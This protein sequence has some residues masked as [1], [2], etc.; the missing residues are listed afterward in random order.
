MRILTLILALTLAAPALAQE[1]RLDRDADGWLLRVDGQPYLV[2]GV[3]WRY[4]PLGRNYSFDAWRDLPRDVCERLVDEDAAQMKKMGVNTI[5]VIDQ[6]GEATWVVRR[7]YEKH[8]IHTI[9]NHFAGRYGVSVD[10]T[11][12]FP[13]NYADKRAREVVVGDVTAWA[14]TYKDVPGV[15]AYALGNEGNYGLEW[16]DAAVAQLPQGERQAAKARQ[17]YS[18][19]DEC[20][21]A[22]KQLD[23]SRPTMIVNG[24]VQY[25][26]LIGEVCPDI[27]ILGM[28]SY[29]G[30]TFTDL[31]D[32]AAEFGK[33][34][35]LMEFGADAFNAVT[36]REDGAAQAEMIDAQLADIAA[37]AHPSLGGDAGTPGSALGGCL[38]QWV[39]EWWKFGQESDLDFHNTQAT[40]HGG[41]YYDAGPAGQN[42]N[43]MNEE[44]W[45][46]N[47]LDPTMTDGL[48][49]RRPRAACDA[50]ARRWNE[51]K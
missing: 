50:I 17:L 47:A 28:N 9:I 18:L 25:L 49:P 30:P 24:E 14:R 8:G 10:G 48:H 21:K 6:T 16:Q 20:V 37:H 13:M 39:D 1:V 4:T 43:N 32:R 2:K 26:D 5:R 12:V 51:T 3:N 36:H 40:W 46:L 41:G 35:V 15:I 33:P 45:G 44:W 29:R 7:F 11:N 23:A 31:W 19:L 34:V 27:D 22:I 42:L 38:F